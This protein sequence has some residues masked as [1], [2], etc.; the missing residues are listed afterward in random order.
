MN[1]NATIAI[2]VIV[3][4]L[5]AIIFI[6]H[7]RVRWMQ[8][9]LDET[10]KKLEKTEKRFLETLDQIE[11]LLKPAGTVTTSTTCL[12]GG[13]CPIPQ[14]PSPQPA[15][16]KPSVSTEAELTELL[17]TVEAIQDVP[18]NG[19]SE[20]VT[21]K[22]PPSDEEKQL[23]AFLKSK[24]LSVRGSLDELRQRANEVKSDSEADA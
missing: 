14:P 21:K 17:K 5:A 3:V 18:Y 20:S 10:E 6:V 23:K 1:P 16:A 12:E 15:K 4:T 9:Q 19:G 11:H 2:T 22:K 8:S 13:E 24:G 7:H